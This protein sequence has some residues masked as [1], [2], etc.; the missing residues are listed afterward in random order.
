[1]KIYGQN[2]RFNGWWYK[3]TIGSM[4]SFKAGGP[5]TPFQDN[6]IYIDT[7]V[8]PIQIY[9]TYIFEYPRLKSNITDPLPEEVPLITCVHT[10]N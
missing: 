8:Y 7:S 4:N 2:S 10:S 1:M 3:D 9:T 5:D 6:Y